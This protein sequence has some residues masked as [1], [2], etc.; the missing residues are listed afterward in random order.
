VQVVCRFLTGVAATNTLDA[1]GGNG[2]NGGNGVGTGTAGRGGGAGFGGFV[3][4]F[5]LSAGT[6]TCLLGP[7]ASTQ[8]TGQ[9]G[10]AAAATFVSL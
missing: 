10:E 7:Q 4:L 9:A 1:R 6:A 8:P 5:N 3:C 2:G